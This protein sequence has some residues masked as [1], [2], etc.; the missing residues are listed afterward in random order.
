MIRQLPGPT[1]FGLW[2]FDGYSSLGRY[3][4]INITNSY[5]LQGNATKIW[6]THTF[7][8]GGDLRRITAVEI[9]REA[10]LG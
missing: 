4:S 7:K 2:Q 6:R 8:I 1:Y 9:S 3:Q 5:N 10:R